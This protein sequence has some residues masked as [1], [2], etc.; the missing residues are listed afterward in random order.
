MRWRDGALRTLVMALALAATTAPSRAAT[1]AEAREAFDHGRY[2]EAAAIWRELARAGNPEAAFQL[3]LVNDLGLGR[4]PDP[5][6]AFRRYLEAAQGG[7]ATAQFNVG[8]MLDA[9]TGTARSPSAAA[10]WYAR[11]AANGVARAEYNLA[12]LYAEG[13]G[14]PRNL[15]LARAWM[16]RAATSLAAAGERLEA[17]G[18]L[19]PEA[20]ESIVAPV[21]LAAAVVTA[22]EGTPTLELVWTAGEQPPGTHYR[23]E[24]DDA[25]RNDIGGDDPARIDV[26]AIAI[27]LLS[28]VPRRWRVL[29]IDGTR[30]AASDWQPLSRTEHEPLPE[31]KIAIRFGSDDA[32]A[33]A[34][35]TELSQD[36]ARS[37]LH[38]ET[39]AVEDTEIA[40]S[41]VRYFFG[42][43]AALA[44]EV[45]AS[46]PTLAD[47]AVFLPDPGRD[48]GTVE[49]RLRG[50][51]AP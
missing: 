38:I 40:A 29:A 5:V 34:F 1:P 15:A 13:D 9:G 11:A 45:A 24:L 44:H 42:G 17:L 51:A 26:S 12:L 36:L 47:Q 7:H 48:P 16:S 23:V 10:T 21:P 28:G 27:P 50:S 14:L 31:G 32:R 18:T 20:T 49:V 35:A 19:D 22:P 3:G 4:A 33:R 30:V 41:E 46:R 39:T 37:G 43:D 25:A 8:V 2:A 6:G